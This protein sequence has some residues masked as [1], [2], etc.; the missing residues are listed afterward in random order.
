MSVEEL[1]VREQD[2][3]KELFHLRIQGVTGEIQSTARIG[4]VRRE[5]AR[6]LTI[7]GEK[8]RAAGK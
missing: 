7:A 3:R 1:R 5:I 4:D 6:V 8:T 2:L